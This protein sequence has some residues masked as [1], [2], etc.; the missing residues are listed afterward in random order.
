M[1]AER[2]N[3]K[4]LWCQPSI[5]GGHKK[6]Y[7]IVDV[8]AKYN[9]AIAELHMIS[10]NIVARECTPYRG[11]VDYF[12]IE[13]SN[14]R[15]SGRKWFAESGFLESPSLTG[16]NLDFEDADTATFMISNIKLPNLSRLDINGTTLDTSEIVSLLNRSPL[17]SQLSLDCIFNTDV[18]SIVASI[19]K[20]PLLKQVRICKSVELASR[21]LK[22]ALSDENT[23]V[24]TMMMRQCR[25][26]EELSPTDYF[27]HPCVTYIIQF[28]ENLAMFNVA[29]MKK[30]D[31]M[32]EAKKRTVH[33][34]Y[35]VRNNEALA[36]LPVELV[37]EVFKIY[38]QED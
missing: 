21:V 30:F 8:I 35:M 37:M 20:M 18:S 24:R 1:K 32:Y 17:L 29:L 11:M 27:L 23:S 9:G 3:R 31:S 38:E 15:D 4:K 36:R 33:F 10:T 16:L 13:S 34:A 19:K 6:T 22:W 7:D 5:S 26:L 25:E 14:I 28:S 2:A 12:A